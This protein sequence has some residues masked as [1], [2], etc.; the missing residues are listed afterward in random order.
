MK[1]YN[2]KGQGLK[3]SLA[4]RTPP[5]IEDATLNAS[6]DTKKDNLINILFISL[7]LFS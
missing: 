4:E 5:T 1:Y 2:S 3:T 6:P 7:N